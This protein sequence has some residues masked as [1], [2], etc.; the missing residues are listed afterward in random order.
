MD[1]A[2]RQLA[3]LYLQGGISSIEFVAQS[4]MKRISARRAPEL[5]TKMEQRAIA[6]WDWEPRPARAGLKNPKLQSVGARATRCG[7]ASPAGARTRQVYE[8]SVGLARRWNGRALEVLPEDLQGVAWSRTSRATWGAEKERAKALM[9]GKSAEADAAAIKE[10]VAG[11]G[12]DEEAIK[13]R[14][15][16]RLPRSSTRSRPSTSACTAGRSHRPQGR[17]ERRRARQRARARRRR[18]DRG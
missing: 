18:L 3:Q 6:E 11:W 4:T 13:A 8:G 15:G 7:A 2:Q 1:A 9:E 14:C 5:A 12:T 17:S 16:A 10:A